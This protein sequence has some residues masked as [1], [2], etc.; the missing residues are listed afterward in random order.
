M[1]ILA[2]FSE[3]FRRGA[4]RAR[5]NSYRRRKMGKVPLKLVEPSRGRVIEFQLQEQNDALAQIYMK[6]LK[7]YMQETFEKCGAQV[8]ASGK[9]I[10]ITFNDVGMAEKIRRELRK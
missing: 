3:G 5:Q 1:G 7:Q 8:K 2:S 9:N 10:R 6:E 4:E